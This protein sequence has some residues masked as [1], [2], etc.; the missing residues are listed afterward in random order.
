[1]LE[2]AVNIGLEFRS[3]LVPVKMR[4]LMKLFSG[5]ASRRHSLSPSRLSP[6]CSPLPEQIVLPCANQLSRTP[7]AWLVPEPTHDANRY[8]VKL[9]AYQ[10]CSAS[11]FVGDRL[12]AG[13]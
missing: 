10:P 13:T 1:M 11:E 2:G 12:G 4:E 5:T 3:E 8:A 9:A 7:P 6:R